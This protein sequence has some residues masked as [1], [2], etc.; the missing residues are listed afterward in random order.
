M[1]PYCQRVRLAI[2][3]N[4]LQD[5]VEEVI[6]TPGKTTKEPWYIKM[7]PLGEI[8]LLVH[9]TGEGKPVFVYHSA[10]IMQYLI[11]VFAPEKAL[12]KLPP[13]E[14][15]YAQILIDY[16]TNVFAPRFKNYARNTSPDQEQALAS[17]VNDSY[18]YLDSVLP[19]SGGF[20]LLGDSMSVVDAAFF[21]WVA[22]IKILMQWKPV[23]HSA[24]VDAWF[25]KMSATK[26]CSSA[27]VDKNKLIEFFHM[28][29]GQY[30][31]QTNGA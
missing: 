13:S 4:N 19:S 3:E 6:V 1:C 15:A 18:R 22:R 5:L 24:K 27:P 29:T 14:F 26:G 25:E 30:F 9:T 7:N 20:L 8:P 12:T 11:S 16:A 17:L 31:K 10:I 21:P 2:C 28:Q 23:T